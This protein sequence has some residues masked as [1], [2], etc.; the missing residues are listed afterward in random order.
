LSGAKARFPGVTDFP[1]LK[2][3]AFSVASL[4]RRRFAP[5][6]KARISFAALRHDQGR[7]LIQRRRALSHIRKS[8]GRAIRLAQ[9]RLIPD[10]YGTRQLVP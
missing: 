5:G 6:L 4:A 7:A 8:A 9:A 1:G 3:G 10:G 2:A